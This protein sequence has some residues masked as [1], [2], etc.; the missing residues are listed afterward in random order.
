[1]RRNEHRADQVLRAGI[2]APAL[3]L[4]GGLA[5]EGTT[6]AIFFILAVVMFFTGVVGFC[7]LYRVLRISTCPRDA[8]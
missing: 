8:A 5:F 1:M 3:L 6:A 2:V 4:V 7:P